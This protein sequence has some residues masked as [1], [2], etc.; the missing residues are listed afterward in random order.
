MKTVL[1][2][3]QAP[4]RP[5]SRHEVAGTYLHKWLHSIGITDQQIATHC[6]FYA[7]TDTFPGSTTSGH[8]PPTKE[9][10]AAHR[11]VLKEVIR[12]L[13]P[14]IIVPVG[15]MAITEL[16]G[17]TNLENAIGKTYSIDPFNSLSHDITCIPLSHPS[18]RSSWNHTHK[19]H[20]QTAL[21]LLKKTINGR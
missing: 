7:L 2:I 10:V 3:G 17:E 14:A 21:A 12:T 20:V 15:K 6:H 16:L 4:A 8:L 5:S 9:Q 11:P 1:F 18:G 13:Q 19:E